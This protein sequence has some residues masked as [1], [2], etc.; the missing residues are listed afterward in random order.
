MSVMPRSLRIECPGAVYHVLN[1]GNYRHDVFGVDGSKEVFEETLF[2]A[3]ER[4]GWI[5]HT[6]CLLDNHYH[7]A[8]ETSDANLSVGMQ[9]LQSTFANR[10][11]RS[12]KER[13]HV[14]QGRYKSLVVE[15][16]AY[17]GP[18]LNYIHLNPLL[19][20][21]KLTPIFLLFF[22]RRV[23]TSLWNYTTPT[24]RHGPRRGRALTNT[25]LKGHPS[26][27]VATELDLTV[28]SVN[29]NCSRVL[30][31]VSGHCRE[32]LEDLG[33]AE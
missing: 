26:A 20:K 27:E 15:R 1:R 9:W 22:P 16:D 12:V 7:M 32:Y 5:L 18:L 31:R 13:G 6:Y 3:C 10:F 30:A 19:R 4:Y 33:D 2:K 8:L 23:G 24:S 11:N 29:V 28:N 17:F 14:F 21:R 25:S